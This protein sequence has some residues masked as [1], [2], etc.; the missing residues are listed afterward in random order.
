[1]GGLV[2]SNRLG[3][4]LGDKHEVTV[5]DRKALYEFSPAF[6]WVMMGWREPRNISRSLNL[7]SKKRVK[8]VNDEVLKIDPA[9]RTV[10]TRNE[11]FAYDYLLIALGAELTPDAI[12]GFSETAHHVYDLQP[13]MKLKE[14]LKGFSGGTVAVGV[15]RMPFKCPAA[16]YETALLMDYHFRKTGIRNKVQ[17]VFFTPEGIPMKVAGPQIGNFVKS[18]LET[19][20][21][22][23]NNNIELASVDAEKKEI[24]FKQGKSIKYDLLCAVP[25]HTAPSVVKDAELTDQSG[26]VPVDMKTFRTKYDDV[27]AIGD[28]TSVKLHN[29]LML[30]KAGV[31]AHGQ[32]EIVA[33][34]IIASIKGGEQKQWKGDGECFIEYGFGKAAMARG[35]FYTEPDPTVKARWPGASLIWHW[36]KVMFEKYWLWRWF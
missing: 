20:D 13:A 4:R 30:P 18:M 16:P 3:M 19:R 9:E 21:I 14:A 7:L 27:F 26:W 22:S 34:N 15:S 32:A 25:P 31:F 23:F 2:A 12:P 6:P 17:I 5:V 8:V 29:G 11:T 24:N 35:N 1:M 10:K 33:H 28:V 36:Y